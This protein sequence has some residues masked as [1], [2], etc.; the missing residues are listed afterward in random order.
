MPLLRTPDW[1]D[2]RL[3]PLGGASDV[4][5]M[6]NPPLFLIQQFVAFPPTVEAEA[7]QMAQASPGVRLPLMKHEVIHGLEEGQQW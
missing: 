7:E 4:T 5:R 3:L 6:Y 1:G 2:L